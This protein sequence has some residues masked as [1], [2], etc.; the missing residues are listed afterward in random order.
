MTGTTQA[1]RIDRAVDALIAGETPVVDPALRPLLDAAATL[2]ASLA[3]VPPSARFEERLA[4]RL[5]GSPHRPVAEARAAVADWSRQQ[6]TPQ[7]LLLTGAVG[8]AVGVAGVAAV[9]FWRATH[10]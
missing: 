3:G 10:R 4:R 6:L 8:S 5:R 1:E 9:A 7:R 2:S